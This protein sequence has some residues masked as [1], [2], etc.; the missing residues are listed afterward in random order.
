LNPTVARVLKRL[1]YPL[2]VILTCVRWYVAYPLSLRHLEEMMSERGTEVDHSTVHR[3]AME[4]LPVFEKVFRRH[5]RTVGKSWRMDETHIKVKGQWKYR[6]RA[7]DKDGNTVD[8]LLR[9]RRDR[10]AA[11]RYFEKSIAHHGA[12]ETVTIDQSGANLTAVKAI[13]AERETPIKIRQRKYLNNIVEQDH[14]AIKRRTRPMLGFKKFGC[15]RILLN[16]IELMHMINKG[17]MKNYGL[18]RTPAQQFY[19][20]VA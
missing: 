14:R 6:Y 7:L 10:L 9:A 15:A 2:D 4:L 18:E 13:N 20:L 19:A 5:K 8:F 12:P 16:G 17:Q 3:W 11:R 1:H